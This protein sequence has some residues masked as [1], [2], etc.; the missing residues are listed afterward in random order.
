MLKQPMERKT[1]DHI[2]VAILLAAMLAAV[3]HQPINAEVKAYLTTAIGLAI[4]LFAY[5]TG[6]MALAVGLLTLLLEFAVSL[7]GIALIY[8]LIAG[9]GMFLYN[10]VVGYTFKQLVNR[11]PAVQT[12]MCGIETSETYRMTAGTVD[13]ILAKVG[14]RKVRRMRIFEVGRCAHCMRDIPLESRACMYCGN[15]VVLK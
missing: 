9:C 1:K 3:I 14:L 6:L 7:P 11:V 4:I 13:S 10:R 5:F 2:A 12:L 8:G 15:E